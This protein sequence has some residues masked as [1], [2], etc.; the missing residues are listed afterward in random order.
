VVA[1]L[2]AALGLLIG[3]FALAWGIWLL[4]NPPEMGPG[5]GIGLTAFGAIALYCGL[6]VLWRGRL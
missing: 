4:A 2:I 5:Y 1:R 6:V 3:L